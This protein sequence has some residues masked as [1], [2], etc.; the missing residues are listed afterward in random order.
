MISLIAQ[1]VPLD[2]ITPEGLPFTADTVGP[3]TESLISTILG[4]LTLVAGLSFILYLV[5][6]G[7]AWI[8][9]AGDPEK[10]KRAQQHINN[11]LIGI[12]IAAIAYT[13]T[14]V[15]GSILN[16]DILNPIKIIEDKLSP[17][18]PPAPFTPGG[19]RY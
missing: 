6:A 13:V 10:V 15:I 16:F 7:L 18:P 1:S 14:A 12:V 4:F 19:E 17:P 9:A 2:T 8:T 3:S 5:I 11:A